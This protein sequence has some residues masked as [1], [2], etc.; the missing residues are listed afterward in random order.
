MRSSRGRAAAPSSGCFCQAER[1]ERAV[2]LVE[3]RHELFE[4][5]QLVARA[6]LKSVE[7]PPDL[8]E[9]L[10][11]QIVPVGACEAPREPLQTPPVGLNDFEKSLVALGGV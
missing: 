8:Q 9:H 11:I 2:D 5:S 1:E 4:D 3:A 6:A 10:L 7:A